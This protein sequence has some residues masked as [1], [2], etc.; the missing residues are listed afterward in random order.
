VGI[1]PPLVT[2]KCEDHL[3]NL[4]CEDLEKLFMKEDPSLVINGKHRVTDWVQFVSM[5]L[6][7]H[8][9]RLPF[10]AFKEEMGVKKGCSFSRLS[11]T[12]FAWREVAALN[13]FQHLE[14]ILLF[15]GKYGGEKLSLKDKKRA[16]WILH[17]KVRNV[18]AL[19][20]AFCFSFTLPAMKAA[21]AIRSGEEMEKFLEWKEEKGK[22]MKRNPTSL[23]V[24][25]QS[26]KR[27]GALEGDALKALESSS[28]LKLEEIA[29][30]SREMKELGGEAMAVSE[31]EEEG[32]GEGE[33]QQQEKHQDQKQ[34]EEE[35]EPGVG[36]EDL[37]L[38]RVEGGEI[39][40]I[41]H[42]E[43]SFPLSPL[44][45]LASKMGDIVLKRATS[46]TPNQLERVGGT[47]REVE[48]MFSPVKELLKRNPGTRIGVIE[49][50]LT[51]ASY[52]SKEVL[53]MKKKLVIPA[54]VQKHLTG[55]AGKNQLPGIRKMKLRD[56][57]EEGEESRRKKARMEEKMSLQQVESA[58]GIH[59]PSK[60]SWNKARS[61]SCLIKMEAVFKKGGKAKELEE[62][63]LGEWRK[64]VEQRKEGN[65]YTVEEPDD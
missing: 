62:Q 44:E 46:N 54:Q 32:E 39:S 10:Q 4:T 33:S 14:L 36:E 26:L 45:E 27:T 3:I 15:F 61:V 42:Q 53:E 49:V 29:W 40:T 56:L 50:Q 41:P 25:S 34:E 35:E 16:M 55:E 8:P 7:R 24:L 31:E 58:L 23:I 64:Y 43:V 28:Q 51:L 5:K 57:E 63:V 48:G 38:G 59:A 17:P 9:L 21:N 18:L 11:D 12:R 60:G 30:D 13:C 22:E 2:I 6:G 52:S 65:P 19:R 37:V 20:A 1:P 47:N